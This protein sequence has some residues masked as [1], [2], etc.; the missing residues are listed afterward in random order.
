MPGWERQSAVWRG[1][2]E[3]EAGSRPLLQLPT[4]A[5][6]APQG[7]ALR[8]PRSRAAPVLPI[9]PPLTLPR[10]PA[11]PLPSSPVDSLCFPSCAGA[12]HCGNE[13]QVHRC[14]REQRHRRYHDHGPGR[15]Q[16]ARQVGGTASAPGIPCW[17]CSASLRCSETTAVAS[18]RFLLP[19]KPHTC[20]HLHPRA[21]TNLPTSPHRPR[22]SLPPCL[23]ACLPARPPA[24][25]QRGRLC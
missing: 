4:A 9:T 1:G 18:L 15:I 7:A 5:G 19:P 20:A 23:P 21:P 6:A 11:A 12:R 14:A 10:C 8:A 17:V 3:L 22:P 2:L 13:V 16:R 25:L 24:C